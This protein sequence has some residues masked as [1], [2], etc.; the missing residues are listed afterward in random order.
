MIRLYGIPNC[1]TVKKAQTWLQDQGL[2]YELH[3]YKK[4][5][6]T[7]E[8]LQQW[9]RE[10][11]WQNLINKAGTT[12][13]GLP[14]AEKAAVQDESSAIAAMTKHTSLIKR[15]IVEGGRQLLIRFDAQAYHDA[16]L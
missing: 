14:E 3:D 12:W 7:P 16:L 10:L 13:R 15:P 11:G 8:K 4:L 2:K 5:G 6:I 1:Q 9:S